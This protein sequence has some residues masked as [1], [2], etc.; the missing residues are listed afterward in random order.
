MLP[1][2]QKKQSPSNRTLHAYT[3]SMPAALLLIVL[4]IVPVIGVALIS[5]TDWRLGEKSFE[6]VGMKNYIKL[7]ADSLFQRSFLNTIVYVLI[8]VPITFSLALG[9][10]IVIES[11]R[12][13]KTFYRTV[14]FLPATATVVAMA[15]VWDFMLHPTLGIFNIVL[16]AV[17]LQG[18][19]WL[20]D[21]GLTLYVL[22]AIGV[23]FRVG[24]LM[25]LFLA[26]LATIPPSLYEA[27]AIDGVSNPWDRF[28]YVTWPLLGATSA[29]AATIATIQAF[30]TFETVA[31]LTQGG[32]ND[33]TEL[34]LHTM[35][36]E[37]FQ[38]FRTG[39][40]AALTVVFLVLILSVTLGRSVLTNMREKHA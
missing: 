3:F 9:T 1:H 4:V 17:G 27:L 40:A 39:Y 32:P 28:R 38:F 6:F 5:T 23:W 22:A 2:A 13:F 12:T 20:R 19:N 34:L 33:A 11:G 35:Y 25:V 7:F 8:V 37:A 10:A 16:D 14:I 36:V 29:F 24:Y 30:Q 26:G 21:E 31:V 15:I 18:H